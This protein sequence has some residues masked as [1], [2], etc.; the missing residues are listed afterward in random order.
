MEKVG[1][2]NPLMDPFKMEANKNV[3]PEYTMDMCPKTLDLLSRAVYINIDPDWT[4]EDLKDR[5]E[6]IKGALIK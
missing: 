5:V 2:L 1:A 6:I 4:E 3:I